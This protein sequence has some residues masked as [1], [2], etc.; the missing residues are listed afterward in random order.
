MN[1]NTLNLHLQLGHGFEHALIRFIA[2]L[3]NWSLKGVVV[4]WLESFFTKAYLEISGYERS[5][6]FFAPAHAKGELKNL[7]SYYNRFQGYFNA[8]KDLPEETLSPNQAKLI[9]IIKASVN[10]LE[11]SIHLL[12][13]VCNSSLPP[14]EFIKLSADK[15]ELSLRVQAIAKQAIYNDDNDWRDIL[16]DDVIEYAA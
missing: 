4:S 6:P 7:Q 5:I 15:K 2:P 16:A 11:N 12:E 8:V 14:K 10:K 13:A 1:D 3:P 9:G